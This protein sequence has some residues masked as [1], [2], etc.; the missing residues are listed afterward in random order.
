MKKI[1]KTWYFLFSVVFIYVVLYFIYTN[2]FWSSFN[3][4]LKTLVKILPIFVFVFIL[5]VVV[6]RY[7]DNKFIINHMRGSKLKSWFYII[8]GGIISTGPMY[9]WYPLLN[10]L[11][12]KGITYGEIAAFLYNRSIKPAFL[13]LIVLYFGFEYTVVLTVVIIFMSFVQA[14]IVELVMSFGVDKS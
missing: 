13:P 6:N 9:M 5:M 8:I 11:R 14:Y 12:D 3:F 10:D 4:F 1:S 2:I 7:I